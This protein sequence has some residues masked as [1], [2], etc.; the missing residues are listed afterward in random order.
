MD[1]AAGNGFIFR[2]QFILSC[3]SD[4]SF[5]KTGKFNP[6]DELIAV[7]GTSWVLKNPSFWETEITYVVRTEPYCQSVKDQFWVNHIYFNE[8]S[9]IMAQ[10][11]MWYSIISIF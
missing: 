8:K 9:R 7:H 6:A 3:T 5:F 4:D 2:Y 11:N 1:A 10:N